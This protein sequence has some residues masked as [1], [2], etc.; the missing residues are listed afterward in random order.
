MNS[1]THHPKPTSSMDQEEEDYDRVQACITLEERLERMSAWGK[2][3]RPKKQQPKRKAKRQL[4][5]DLCIKK[6]LRKAANP[7]NFQGFP[8]EKCCYAPNLKMEVYVPSSYARSTLSTIPESFRKCCA[9]CM[10]TPCLMEEFHTQFVHDA[11]V[12]I[13]TKQ[14]PGDE[15]QAALC[16][17]IQVKIVKVFNKTYLKKFFPNPSDIPFCAKTATKKILREAKTHPEKSNYA[18]ED[19]TDTDISTDSNLFHF[20]NDDDE[21]DDDIPDAVVFRLPKKLG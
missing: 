19:D 5:I 16:R 12:N 14:L 7:K 8:I 1:K 3:K 17:S 11:K 13:I 15:V 10:L 18:S 6:A 4:K 9:G 21:E 20:L 2:E